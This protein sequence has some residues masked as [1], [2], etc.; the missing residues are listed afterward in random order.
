[1]LISLINQFLVQNTL[2]GYPVSVFSHCVVK[3]KVTYWGCVVVP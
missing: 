3:K 1:M 2:D